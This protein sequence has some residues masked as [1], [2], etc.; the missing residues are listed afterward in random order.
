MYLFPL[1][2]ILFTYLVA[3]FPYL[4]CAGM[5]TQNINLKLLLGD[6]FSGFLLLQSTLY[7]HIFTIVLSSKRHPKIGTRLPPLPPYQIKNYTAVTSLQGTEKCLIYFGTDQNPLLG[8][9]YKTFQIPIY[10]NIGGTFLTM[11]QLYYFFASFLLKFVRKNCT[12]SFIQLN[13]VFLL[14]I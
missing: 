4:K 10:L 3:S 5:G 11:K 6:S 13:M 1:S 12:D 14:L 2:K 9:V 8:K 7:C